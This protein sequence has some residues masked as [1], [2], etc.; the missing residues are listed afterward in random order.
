MFKVLLVDDEKIERE[1]ISRLI[2]W[3]A[4]SIN[5][6]GAARNGIVAWDL[7]AR[8]RPDIVIT[9]IK[10]PVVSG[11]DL[12]D[13]A[14][15]EFPEIVFIVLSGYGDY[16][17]TSRAMLFGVRHYLLKPVTEGQILEVLEDAERELLKKAEEKKL[18][19]SLETNFEK[20]LPH[21][22]QQFLRDAVLTGIH[23]PKDSDYYKTL[24]S[25]EDERFRIVLCS[26]KGK[27]DFIDKFALKNIAEE[28]LGTVR[29]GTIIESEVVLLIAGGLPETV[30]GLGM[31]QQKYG[32]YFKL[33]LYSSV[34][35][36]GGFDRIHE[37]YKQAAELIR[38][39]FEFGE[40]TVA[41]SGSLGSRGADGA[42]DISVDMDAVCGCVNGGGIGDLNLS[43][44][45]FFSRM[46]REKQRLPQIKERCKGLLKAILQLGGPALQSQFAEKLRQ[47]D[48]MEEPE[49][50]YAVV[51]HVANETAIANASIEKEAASRSPAVDATVRCIYENISNPQLSLSWIA[52]NILFLNREYLGRLFF[53]EMN[54]RF[55]QYVLRIR[56]EM[57]KKLIENADDLKIRE[58]SGMTGFSEDS[59]YFSRT[60]KSYTGCTPSD[61]K[62]KHEKAGGAPGGARP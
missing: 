35:D 57:A 48:S 9:D 5:F 25:L 43:L 1:S 20:M 22:K 41:T 26:I 13:R 10:M 33:P 55:S 45:I 15:K 61:Y 28:I 49:P 62:K 30:D 46:R 27:C 34:S 16:E 39:R 7:I 56:M 8:H 52:R 17:F 37:M 19:S 23:G 60:F 50:I 4:H 31:V 51:K 11:L 38:H 47:I 29:L 58:I 40:H 12:I 2:D 21:V 6:I 59:Q 54:E 44:E 14:G 53:R 24:F 36:P 3:N 42:R 32:E 18:V